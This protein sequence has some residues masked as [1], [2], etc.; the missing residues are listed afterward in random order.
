M[1]KYLNVVDE[2]VVLFSCNVF[3]DIQLLLIKFKINF[4]ILQ[5]INFSQLDLPVFL[6]SIY[7]S[8]S[9]KYSWQSISI[10]RH[11]IYPNPVFPNS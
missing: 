6:Y 11:Y 8:N 10:I 2:M 1:W 9:Y 4:L 7:Y 5:Q 3:N